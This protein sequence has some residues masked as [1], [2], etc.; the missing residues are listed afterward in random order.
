MEELGKLA[1]AQDL[2]LV[3]KVSNLIT[4]V[5]LSSLQQSHLVHCLFY[6]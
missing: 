3:S 5:K 2:M 4:S 6:S 1:Q